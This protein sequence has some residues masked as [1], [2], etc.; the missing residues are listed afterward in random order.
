MGKSLANELTTEPP[1][2]QK[3]ESQPLSR[4]DR[5]RIYVAIPLTLL[6]FNMAFFLPRN[7]LTNYMGRHGL[8]KWSGWVLA[9]LPLTILLL[10]IPMGLLSDRFSPRR[11]VIVGLVFLVAFTG[12]FFFRTSEPTLPML[13]GSFLL[14]GI[15]IAIA[16]T[17]LRPLYLKCI[18]HRRQALKLALL[19]VVTMLGFGGS[20]FL[21]GL[22]AKHL[23]WSLDQ[24]YRL[25]FPLALAGLV[26]SL[27]VKDAE[28]MPFDLSAYRQSIMRRKVLMYLSLV[29]FNAL[30]FGAEAVCIP[31][32]LTDHL[33]KSDADVG[34]YFGV[35]CL[36]MAV[37]AAFSAL[38]REHS[39]NRHRMWVW[40]LLFSATFNIVSVLYPT[41][42]WFLSFRIG[43]VVAD[44]IMLNA[45]LR[46]VISLFPRKR[47]AGPMGLAAMVV[48]AGVLVGNLVSNGIR[49]ADFIPTDW[50][51]PAPFL[52][53]GLLVY[54]GLVIQRIMGER[55]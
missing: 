41:L 36:T 50:Q 31:P 49:R 22:A 46:I 55:F 5:L 23:D 20:T 25:A 29:F 47:M 30:H 38:I 18:G 37:T 13:F 34:N 6:L 11:L 8:G 21:G 1:P 24:Q 44:A 48:T 32:Y 28:P 27:T 3:V 54:V 40:G 9:V 45:G 39:A 33:G 51:L 12:I 14:G 2:P 4:L 42:W 7:L 16:D 53:A 35:I 52:L 43:H 26:I 17:S 10:A 19:S 15:A